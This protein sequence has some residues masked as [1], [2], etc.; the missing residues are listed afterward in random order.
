MT[1]APQPGPNPAPQPA[2][3]KNRAAPLREGFTT[4]TA[5]TAAA[6]AA[7]EFLLLNQREGCAPSLWTPSAP[8]AKPLDPD[9]GY[10]AIGYRPAPQSSLPIFI[11][12]PLPPAQ[13]ISSPDPD[14]MGLGGEGSGEG[15]LKGPR[16]LRFPSPADHLN[17]PVTDCRLINARTARAEVVKDGGDDPDATHGMVIA[18]EVSLF[19]GARPCEIIICGGEGIGR[20]T[21]PGLPLPVGAWAINPAPKSQIRSALSALAEKYGYRGGFYV[22]VLA[23]EGEKRARHTLNA[24]LGILGGISILGTSG[25]VKPY[26]H[27]AWE[28][29]IRQGAALAKARGLAALGLSTGGRSERLLMA[30]YPDWP[31]QAFVQMADFA[32]AGVR[33]AAGAGFRELAV[34]L[35]IGKLLK[36]AQGLEY[37]HAHTAPLELELPAAWAQEAGF[38]AEDAEELRGCNTAQQALEL[39]LRSKAKDAVFEAWLK[40]TGA[41]LKSWSGPEMKITVHLFDLAGF[42]LRRATF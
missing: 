3:I 38:A 35:Y 39:V 42:E 26:S 28:E 27:A 29:V 31:E 21:L 22:R 14:R 2:K 25:R 41:A 24:R 40:R 9:G 32:A 1:T 23:P 17:I 16:P 12:T 34:G 33:A 36:I 7:A 19:T 10:G 4:G 6:L 13:S 18:A 15:N 37:T 20:A 30:A 11:R 5:A 8:G